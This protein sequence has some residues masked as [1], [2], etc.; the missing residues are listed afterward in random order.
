MVK[1]QSPPATKPVAPNSVGHDHVP[2]ST[3]RVSKGVER[4]NGTSRGVPA[5]G[6][7]KAGLGGGKSNVTTRPKR[8]LTKRQLAIDA[9]E[10]LAA[11]RSGKPNRS[12]AGKKATAA[13]R[14]VSVEDPEQSLLDQTGGDV[15][16]DESDSEGDVELVRS[17]TGVSSLNSQS[18]SVATAAARAG[19]LSS[20]VDESI[21]QR[22]PVVASDAVA[23]FI[24][25]VSAFMTSTST[26]VTEQPVQVVTKDAEKAERANKDESGRGKSKSYIKLPS[27]DGVSMNFEAYLN[28]FQT[29]QEHEGWTADQ[30]A[31]QLRMQLRGRAADALINNESKSWSFER[32]VEE[33]KG[34]FSASALAEHYQFQIRTRRRMK[35]ETLS[36]LHNDFMRL[37]LL[38]YP[39]EQHTSIYHQ[40]MVEGYIQSLA[41]TGLDA[42]VRDRFPKTL[43]DAYQ[44]SVLLE[45]NELFHSSNQA[46][47]KSSK[48]HVDDYA[49]AIADDTESVSEVEQLRDELRRLKED[50]QQFDTLCA[51]VREIKGATSSA[52]P[53]Y[54]VNRGGSNSNGG[55]RRGGR[56][57]GRGRSSS[58]G[59]TVREELRRL[60]DTV[61]QNENKASESDLRAEIGRLREQLQRATT[62]GGANGTTSTETTGQSTRTYG[63]SGAS[64]NGSRGGGESTQLYSQYRSRTM[65]NI[66]CWNCGENG[67]MRHQCTSEK[68]KT[69]G[70]GRVSLCSQVDCMNL[71][72]AHT[73]VRA[74]L[75]FSA[76]RDWLLDS[77]ADR[78]VVPLSWIKH[79]PWQKLDVAL[80]A[81]N[82]TLIPVVG[83]IETEL[84]FW[85]RD[86]TVR[87]TVQLW[88]TEHITCGILGA[89]FMKQ[90]LSL[91]DVLNNVVVIK[92]H[93][94]SL[95]AR[96]AAARCNRLVA[97]Y[98]TMIP[99]NSECLVPAML[100]SDSMSLDREPQATEINE[101][102]EGVCT[103]RVILPR[104]WHDLP[105][106]VMNVSERDYQMKRGQEL[107]TIEPVEVLE[108]TALS[109]VKAESIQSMVDRVDPS[110]S[111][112][113]KAA[114]KA[115][116]TEYESVFSYHEFDLGRATAFKHTIDTGDAMPIRQRLRPQPRVKQDEIDRQVENMVEQGVIEESNSPWAS[117]VVVVTKKDGSARVCIDYRKLNS[118]TRKDAYPLPR[119]SDCLDALGG[120]K[121]F[122]SFDL[123]AGYWQMELQDEASK[124]RTSFIT[125]RG[126]FRFN[127]LAFGLTG[128][129]ASFMRLMDTVMR[130]L[131]FNIL[132][133]Y[134]DDIVVFSKDAETHL[135]RL[136]LLFARLQTASL[137]LKPSKC[138]LMQT[139]IE[140]LGF[141]V[142]GNGIRTDPK[143]VETVQTWP[144]PTNL[145]EVRSFVGLCSYYRKYVS[146]FAGLCAPLHKLTHKHAVFK[147]SADC[148]R[149]FRALKEA[150]TESP[151]LSM[152]A[153][154]GTY[155][156]DTDASNESI[157]AVLQQEQDG[158]IKVIAYASRLLHGP[159]RNYCVTR[160]ELLAVV[161]YAKAFRNY[162]LGRKFIVRT[163]HS[164]LRWLRS[165][166]EP[167]GQQ[168]RWNEILEEFDFSIE[169]RAG[170]KHTNADALSRR[171]CRQC[172]WT[173]D[174]EFMAKRVGVERIAAT[175]VNVAPQAMAR[176]NLTIWSSEELQEMQS[177]DEDLTAIYRLMAE[178]GEDEDIPWEEVEQ[179]SQITRAYWAQR[180][181]LCMKDG[182]LY[183]KWLRLGILREDWLMVI[184][185]QLRPQLLEQAHSGLGGGHLGVRRTLA[186]LRQCY[187]WIGQSEDTKRYLAR[188][189]QCCRYHRGKQPKQGVLH[190]T[191]VVEPFERIG[192]D[193]TGPHPVSKNGFKYILTII[194]LFSKYSVCVAMRNHEATTVAEILYTYWITKFGA[195]KQ[196]LSDRGAEFESKL[197]ADLCRLLGIQKLRSTSYEPR[198]CGCVERLHLTLN[199]MLAKAMSEGQTDWDRHLSA[200]TAAYN[201]TVQ[202]STGYSPYYILYGS[203]MRTPLEIVAGI[204]PVDHEVSSVDEWVDRKLQ[205]LSRAH[206]IVR[207]NL[208][209]AAER[210][211]TY[212]DRR[213]KTKQFEE[214]QFVW[215]FNPRRYVHKSHKWTMMY[216]G[217][218]RVEKVLSD[219]NLVVKRTPRADAQVVHI[220]KVKLYRGDLP[221]V[222]TGAEMT[223]EEHVRPPRVRIPR[224]RRSSEAADDGEE[225]LESQRPTRQRTAPARLNDYVRGA[226]ED[227]DHR[228]P[229]GAPSA[230]VAAL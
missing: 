148:E 92:G 165:T 140:F 96:K 167:I 202:E 114:L 132:L 158:E 188:C 137:K 214:G 17:G 42:K 130:G 59:P 224:G 48:Q 110:I 37:G 12:T 25:K 164:A 75:G 213:V 81:A 89:D 218:Y 228:V 34:R 10:A 78:S 203:E 199:A 115:L 80:K 63:Q 39:T 11:A 88:A 205:I 14:T 87:A 21:P 147:W 51:E 53:Q 18:S 162:L 86:D 3:K 90:Y 136:R 161:F 177:K 211:K 185:R 82:D 122:S 56:G 125:R 216:Y 72:S 8:R 93:R 103:A 149:G 30:A 99:A 100:Q 227:S 27:F 166:P 54:T 94:I 55:R 119:I 229:P 111:I 179:Y 61:Q 19:T 83:E 97:Q 66:Q 191:V 127:V 182:V 128:A 186:R 230:N 175:R 220:D 208:G 206:N 225:Q 223:K 190:P 193:I 150:L 50:R 200:V 1:K 207:E 135:E 143:K 9:E 154:E 104:G 79:L 197:M 219:V 226:V 134:L 44:I 194:D 52:A 184:P 102:K 120:M 20:S 145:H 133:C 152:P 178:K 129:P 172:G 76:A 2:P 210:S 142:G 28:L 171:P 160:K 64:Y 49:C 65:D 126:S 6:T 32:L 212:Y 45:G 43:R 157:A 123:R 196:I 70:G 108:S 47:S 124:D 131:N 5:K 156:L 62:T 217:P 153:D 71:R 198:T 201:A 68:V 113:H 46:S 67:H 26:K 73:Y 180:Q 69:E 189:E 181:Q 121:Y 33:L 58:S 141:I 29:A 85:G 107:T 16:G 13:R 101:L 4:D 106:R 57:G 170:V 36:Q 139:S 204:N 118:V 151:V 192:I 112:E 22:P 84:S 116:L 15:E 91:W 169:H 146:D 31:V 38:A 144:R 195:P 173:A 95:S 168:A 60:Q 174:G 23:D 24:A 7:S 77:G 221:A 215:V 155:Y 41:G 98:D 187:Y 209:R 138:Q 222:W 40:M 159:E 176:D 109:T 35:G 117:N 163:D 183:R 105:M 74:S